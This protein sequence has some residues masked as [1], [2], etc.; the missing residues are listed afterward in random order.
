MIHHVISVALHKLYLG[1]PKQ[2][3]NDEIQGTY[4]LKIAAMV[5]QLINWVKL[6]G[7]PTQK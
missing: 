6:P 4:L 2:I 1:A 7:M 3:A 5:H